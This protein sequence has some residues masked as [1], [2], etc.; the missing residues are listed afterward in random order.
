MFIPGSGWDAPPP[1]PPPFPPTVPFAPW[2]TWTG[3]AA[4]S[5]PTAPSQPTSSRGGG[6]VSQATI[7]TMLSTEKKSVKAKL[8][9]I[10]ALLNVAVADADADADA[11]VEPMTV[12]CRQP[13]LLASAA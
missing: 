9:E 4:S 1:P 12:P 10:V 11:A 13:C 3:P 5:Q 8:S 2:T 6:A 7:T